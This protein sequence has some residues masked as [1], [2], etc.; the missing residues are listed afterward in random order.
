MNADERTRERDATSGKQERRRGPSRWL[1][2][3]VFAVLSVGLYTAYKFLPVDEYLKTVLDWVRGLGIWGPL[4]IGGLYIPA[5]VLLVPGSLVTIGAGFLFGVVTGTI[6]VSAGSTI[7]ACIP[8]R[9]HHRPQLGGEE[10]IRKAKIPG[11]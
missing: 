2:V 11:H 1:P 5:C 7:G 4:V 10:A 8:G 3:A 9:P 6:A